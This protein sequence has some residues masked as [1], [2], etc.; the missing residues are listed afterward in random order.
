ME[1]YNAYGFAEFL[2]DP[3]FRDWV[4]SGCGKNH[5]VW[6]DFAR[7]FPAKAEEMSLAMDVLKDLFAQ[8]RSVSP[9]ELD[10][11]V[12]RI[13]R[14]TRPRNS[15]RWIARSWYWA[16][17]AVLVGL[18]L[19]LIFP[20]KQQP[21]AS[22]LALKSAQTLRVC[23]EVNESD[24]IASLLLPDGST[25]MLH[26]GA[27]LSYLREG[28]FKSQDDSARREVYVSGD[29]FF[30]VVKDK[31]WPFLV[32]TDNFITT[33]VGTS[34]LVK[35]SSGQTSVEVRTGKVVLSPLS[36]NEQW[37]IALTPNQ[38]AVSSTKENR[39]VKELAAEPVV[40]PDFGQQMTFHYE[41]ASIGSVF[42]S[43]ELAYGVP[44]HFNE[45]VFSDCRISVTMGEEVFEEKLGII[46]ETI[47]AD[48]SIRGGE[49]FVIGDACR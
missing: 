38:K 3:D 11:E 14:S 44:I 5:P 27:R 28:F 7:L 10:T 16:A 35:S 23:N 18:S 34:F 33:V 45:Q 1:K 15:I 36:V 22:Y 20:E 41:N 8:K 37:E 43:L 24:S 40:L 2:A 47:N 17:A 30:D 26:P 42:K 4:K 48:F 46:C 6:S 31:S 12:V 21:P 25:A 39:P 19:W 32:Y 9:D 49:V 29:V 13:L